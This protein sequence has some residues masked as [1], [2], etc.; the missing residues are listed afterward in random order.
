MTDT[1]MGMLGRTMGMVA[2]G[3]AAGSQRL[4]PGGTIAGSELAHRE[5]TA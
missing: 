1:Q 2:A 4:R 5:G 3:L